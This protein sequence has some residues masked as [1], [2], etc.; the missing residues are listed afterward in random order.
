MGYSAFVSCN[1]Y[2]QGLATT[3]PY[4][5]R[6]A[7]EED[8]SVYLEFPTGL[9]E[10]DQPS[11]LQMDN[12]FD[13]WQAHACAHPDMHAAYERLANMSGMGA[14]RRIVAERGA[15]GHFP[16][17]TEKLP[18]GNCGHLPAADAPALLRE[19]AELAAEPAERIVALRE[20][21]SGELIY[22]VNSNSQAIFVFATTRYCYGLDE[23]GFFIA[24][25]KKSWFKRREE[26]L[27]RFRARH[28]R[29][30]RLTDK[31]YRFSDLG[32]GHQYE[33]VAGLRVAEAEPT[34]GATFSVTPETV[35]LAREYAY[36]LAPL[37]RLAEV[38][39][40]TG[41]PICWT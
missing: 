34:P 32:S 37:Q 27:I 17:L 3:P 36:I 6:I 1:C 10:R 19:L 16:V 4:P 30:V 11:F 29:Q 2:K 5:E 25:K 22:S 21:A 31:L 7:I 38:S 20:Q 18:Q 33:C 39:L 28:F 13:A 14:F 40:Q 23:E 12:A 8:G 26:H 41:N 35:P 15:D 9:W 24:E